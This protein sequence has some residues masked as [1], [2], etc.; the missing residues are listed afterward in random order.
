M[1]PSHVNNSSVDTI[2]LTTNLQ[3]EVYKLVLQQT[4]LGMVSERT[5]FYA[6]ISTFKAVNR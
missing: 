4:E 6:D 3:S 2:T 5:P 1:I